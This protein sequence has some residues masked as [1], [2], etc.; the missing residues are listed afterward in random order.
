MKQFTIIKIGYTAGIYGCSN[1][2]FTLIISNKWGMR[3]LTFYGMYGAEE[4]VSRVIEEYG[5]KKHYT[6]SIYGRMTRKDIP[7]KCV[8]SEYT[9]IDTIKSF[10]GKKS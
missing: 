10:I 9:A 5:Y 2:Y 8:E 4:R 3:Y 6:N 1:E 7:S